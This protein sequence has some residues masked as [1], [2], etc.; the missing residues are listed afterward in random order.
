MAMGPLW[1]MM[2]NG[3]LHCSRSLP[4]GLDPSLGLQVKGSLRYYILAFQFCNIHRLC[5]ARV[6]GEQPGRIELHRY[7][8]DPSVGWKDHGT[9]VPWIF[10]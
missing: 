1:S 2:M 4:A 7:I 3:P 10:A 5:H 8:C 6:T 9:N